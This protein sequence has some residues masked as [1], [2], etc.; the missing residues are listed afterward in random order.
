MK[1][2]SYGWWFRNPTYQLI[3]WIS[4]Y[5]PGFLHRRWWTPDFFHQQYVAEDVSKVA[6][7]VISGK[8]DIPT[9]KLTYPWKMMVGRCISYWN[10]P[11]LGD[12][13]VFWGVIIMSKGSCWWTASCIQFQWVW[14]A[15]VNSLTNMGFSEEKVW[16]KVST[17]A[18]G[19]NYLEL[20]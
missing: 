19:W 16:G 8:L 12:M 10:S 20:L 18:M 14:F 5:W 9:W 1:Y 13:L 17:L 2:E 15:K 6:D 3:W 4:H 11:F 7:K